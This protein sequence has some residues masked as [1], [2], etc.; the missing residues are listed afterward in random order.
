M[1]AIVPA[2]FE[3]TRIV[4][5]H[6]AARIAGNSLERRITVA[7]VSLCIGYKNL[8]GCLLDRSEEGRALRLGA[9]S[10]GR[11][12]EFLS[13]RGHR[14]TPESPPVTA[15]LRG[16]K[17]KIDGCHEAKCRVARIPQEK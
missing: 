7:D 1:L 5:D 4:P 8:F 11:G 2:R 16:Q 13:F 9:Q 3:E 10:L 15:G 17:T 14:C 6:L 12:A